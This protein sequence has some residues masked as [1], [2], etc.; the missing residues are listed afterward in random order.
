MEKQINTCAF[1]D[2]LNTCNI[3]KKLAGKELTEKQKSKEAECSKEK[4]DNFRLNGVET[5]H[6]H[7]RSCYADYALTVKICVYV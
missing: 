5:L 7:M 3:N 2:I 6:I 1:R 4:K